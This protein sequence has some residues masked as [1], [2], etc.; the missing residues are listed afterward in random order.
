MTDKEQL[1]RPKGYF[2]D[3]FQRGVLTKG[4]GSRIWLEERH[5]PLNL[6]KLIKFI[7][8]TLS[9]YIDI[10]PPSSF[11]I[12]LLQNQIQFNADKNNNQFKS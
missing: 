5:R 9:S 3:R 8:Y 1:T 12:S 6:N 2:A 11:N 10:S 4:E 7:K